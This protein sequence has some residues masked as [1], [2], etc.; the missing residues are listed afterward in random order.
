MH[1]RP[2]INMRILLLGKNGQVGWQLQSA[3]A[4]L[5][6]VNALGH[7]ELDLVN[8]SELRR[9]VQNYKPNVIVNAAAYTDVDRA[10]SEP[11]YAMKVNGI[12]PGILAEEAKRIRAIYID[13]STDYVFN[14]MKR[15]AYVEE[16]ETDPINVYG[17]TKLAGEQAIQ[18]VGG[19]HFI[20]RTSWV[21]GMRGRNFFLTILRLARERDILQVV[22]DQVGAPTWCGAIART[23]VFMLS[24]VL[25]EKDGF[26]KAKVISGVYQY[27]ASGQTTWFG[28]AKAIL[29]SAHKN[30]GRPLPQL[31]QIPTAE[32]PSPARRPQY[33]VLSLDKI[34][35]QF[36][37][38]P[39]GWEEQLFLAWKDQSYGI[40]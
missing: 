1:G 26:E 37:I 21:Y 3:L 2:K 17:K 13:Y 31:I 16:D 20:I 22:D 39:L 34:C 35:E 25:T 33:T 4:Q 29:E 7:A 40:E 9:L 23:T 24:R 8:H 15:S 38:L 6:D 36:G 32:Y 19:A 12:A 30:D 28:F 5:G 11:E 10:E 18:A 27:A 14:G